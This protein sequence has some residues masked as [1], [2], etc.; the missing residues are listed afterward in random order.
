MVQSWTRE[1]KQGKYKARF[2]RLLK[3]AL[4]SALFATA[5]DVNIASVTAPEAPKTSLLKAL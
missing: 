3:T 4:I 5:V 2:A 1:Q